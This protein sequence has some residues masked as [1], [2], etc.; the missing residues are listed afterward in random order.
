M[1]N[2]YPDFEEFLKLL[3]K[4]EVRYLVVGG[5]AFAVHAF[6]RFT[7]DLDIWI[8]A[9]EQ[10]GERVLK[11]LKEFGFQ[12]LEVAIEDLTTPDKIIQI[13]YPPLRIDILTSIDGVEFGE[14]WDQK[15]SGEY[16]EQAMQLIN[17]DHLIQNKK[18]SGREKDQRDLKDLEKY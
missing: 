1:Q 4:N 14:A 7:N 9:D 8:D 12:E 11:T 18:A 3:N 5:Y 17:R 6:P 16:G 10:N 15:I 13:G 2:S